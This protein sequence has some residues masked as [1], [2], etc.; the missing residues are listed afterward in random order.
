VVCDHIVRA[1]DGAPLPGMLAGARTDPAALLGRVADE[2]ESY[3]RACLAPW[4]PR[5]RA[6]LEADIAYRGR[7]L[8]LGGA[9]ALFADLDDRVS[10]QNGSLR[11]ALR[12]VG[13][14]RTIRVGGRG[15]V[16]AP[17]LFVCNALTMIDAG[18]PPLLIYPARGRAALWEQGNIVTPAV[19]D[20]LLGRTRS[21]LLALLDEPASTTELA[22]LLDV[23]PGAVS[24]HLTALHRA[25]L[26]NRARSGRSVLYF[27]SP[28]GDSLLG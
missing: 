20:E 6:L 1:Y 9:Q 13:L 27:R 4:W 22:R 3:W 26:L 18:E 7:G 24:R 21:R 23:T 25:R 15:L 19:L 28:L 14:D 2:L 16:L 11:I 10:W 12:P 8:A 17:C 5:M